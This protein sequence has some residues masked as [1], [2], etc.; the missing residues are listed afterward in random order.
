MRETVELRGGP[1]DGRRQEVSARTYRVMFPRTDGRIHVDYT[2]LLD[3]GA[4][5]RTGDG[6]LIYVCEALTEE[7]QRFVDEAFRE[8]D[9]RERERELLHP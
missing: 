3:A 7:E 2:P 5:V 9:R 4:P 8:R 6:L 1:Y